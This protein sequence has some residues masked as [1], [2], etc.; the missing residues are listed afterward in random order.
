MKSDKLEKVMKY[1]VLKEFNIEVY[2]ILY[3]MLFL[4]SRIC[5]V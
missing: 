3:K 4:E 2:L 1:A 5:E